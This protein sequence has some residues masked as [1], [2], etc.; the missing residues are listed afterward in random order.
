MIIAKL[1][2]STCLTQAVYDTDRHEM[3]LEFTHGGRYRYEGVPATVYR[4]LVRADSP[5]RAFH[6]TVRGRFVATRI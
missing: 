4:N 1:L 6:A 3:T 2:D 5:G